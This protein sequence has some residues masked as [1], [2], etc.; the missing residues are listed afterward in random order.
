MRLASFNVEN[1][2]DRAMAL[3]GASWA[4]GR[5]ALQAHQALNTLFGKAR[6]SATDRKRMLGLMAEHGLLRS[7]EGPLLRLRKIR[8]QLIQRPRQGSPLRDV[9]S[10][11]AYDDGGW[12]GTHG[13]CG[14]SAKLDHLLL[15]PALY[16]CVTAAGVERRGMWGGVNG[17]LWPHFDEVTRADEAASDHAALWVDLDL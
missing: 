13:N 4:E 5:P 6:Y 11:P 12:P 2:F 15:S 1:M 14:P 10:H 8:G 16:A 17:T 7:D 9:S 3:N